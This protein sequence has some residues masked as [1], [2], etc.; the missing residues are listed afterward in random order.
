MAVSYDYYRV[1]YHVARCGSFTRA[2]G[3]LLSNQPNITRVINNLE[4]ELGCRLFLRSRR[5]V[6]LTPEGEALFARVQVAQE[7]LQAAEY[8]LAQGRKLQSGY[9][10][11]GASET[12]LHGLLLPVLRQFRR[13]YPGVHI[14][15]TNHSTPQA[16]TAVRSGL[17]ELAVVTTPTGLD[18]PL[19]EVP[20]REFQDILIAGQDYAPLQGR[21]LHLRELEDYPLICLGR[22][23]KTFAFFSRLFMQHGLVLRPD[24]EAA[25]TGQI[26]PMVKSGLGLGLLPQL[27]ALESLQ[28]GEIFQIQLSEP[29]PKR[30][31]CLVKDRGRPLS[32]AAQA[33]EKT[34][35]QAAQAGSALP[36]AEF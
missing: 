9:I 6:T 21:V 13:S 28:K 12:A 14:Q 10:S 23:T 8:E 19:I 15:I 24:I 7:Q 36:K 35:M 17:V 22:E 30:G 16:V 31:I 32:I 11:L 1:F 29:I 20:L 2:A 4:Q 34:I 18:R 26:L 3:V 33:L 25:T 27:F 5:G